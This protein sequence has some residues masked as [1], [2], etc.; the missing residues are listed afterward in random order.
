MT[1]SRGRR[2]ALAAALLLSFARASPT[3]LANDTLTPLAD[4]PPA[5]EFSLVD[6][7]GRIHRL[8]DYR[9]RVLIVNFWATWCPPCR[10]E[11]PSLDRARERLRD[12]GV[13]ILAIN[14]GEDEETV[15]TFTGSYPVRFP[16]LFDADGKVTERWPVMGL[17][18]TF[19]VGPEG[20][21]IYRAVGAREWDSPKL[22]DA[23]R[24]LAE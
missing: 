8:R 19:V 6:L 17:P 23:V 13:E 3:A 1:R 2:L 11:M 24:Q 5:P 4:K 9:G 12:A 20:R 15:F 22:M 21:L 18:T 14:V 16:L 10:K 7:E